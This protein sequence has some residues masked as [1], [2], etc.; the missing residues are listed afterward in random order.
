MVLSFD[1]NKFHTIDQYI[2]HHADKL[3]EVLFSV[4]KKLKEVKEDDS[5]E[6]RQCEQELETMKEELFREEENMWEQLA[7]LVV[8]PTAFVRSY[9]EIRHPRVLAVPDNASVISHLLTEIERIDVRRKEL[10]ASVQKEREK[11]KQEIG[12]SDVYRIF[13]ADT[14][15]HGLIDGVM[16]L[17]E[18][19]KKEDMVLWH[20]VKNQLDLLLRENV[21]FFLGTGHVPKA[22]IAWKRLSEEKRNHEEASHIIEILF[23]EHEE[24]GGESDIRKHATLTELAARFYDQIKTA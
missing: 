9:I 13:S 21:L 20:H 2:N 19:A 5:K 7:A 22:V 8:Y 18:R 10:V 6:A 16:T 14:T 24:S 11:E 15:L 23:E 17:Y 1:I 12:I 4:E 3:R